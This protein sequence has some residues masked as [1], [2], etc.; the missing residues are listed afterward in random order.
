MNPLSEIIISLRSQ[1]FYKGYYELSL[2][3][4]P[5][6]RVLSKGKPPAPG[7]NEYYIFGTSFMDV[8]VGASFDV[9]FPYHH[10]EEYIHA[11]SILKYVNVNHSYEIDYLPN[12]Y[13]GICL[14]E[15][16]N[17]KPDILKKLA[18]YGEKY[19]DSIHDTLILTQ[20]PIIDKIL[21]E[22]NNRLNKY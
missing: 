17:G 8:P 3:D 16:P 7:T 21:I 14:I 10:V 1:D 2:L 4:I 13:S 15:F 9:I 19:D 22:L 12:G 6:E 18:V 20:K 5:T 11:A